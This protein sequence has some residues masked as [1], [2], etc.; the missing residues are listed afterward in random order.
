MTSSLMYHKLLS[1]NPSSQPSDPSKTGIQV[2]PLQARNQEPPGASAQQYQCLILLCEDQ[3]AIPDP[4]TSLD[5]LVPKPMRSL[6]GE[7]SAQ[8]SAIRHAQQQVSGQ[9]N[10]L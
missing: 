4:C 1:A 7:D 2:S 8:A 6:R 3:G 10:N 5:Y 9:P